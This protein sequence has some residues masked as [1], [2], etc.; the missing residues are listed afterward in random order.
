[1]VYK[2][3][4]FKNEI[5]AGEWKTFFDLLLTAD[6]KLGVKIITQGNHIDFFVVSDKKVDTL[7]SR[8][9]PFYLS[10]EISVKERE[11]SGVAVNGALLA[12]ATNKS[13]FELIE[14]SSLDN[15]S[16]VE[17]EFSINR[18]NPFKTAPWLG[19]IYVKDRGYV[20]YKKLCL[21]HIYG[22][23]AFD[24]SRSIMFEVAKVR[25]VLARGGLSFNYDDSGMMEIRGEAGKFG[26]KSYDFWR[27]S[28]ILGQSGSGKSY[29][30]KLLID[31]LAKKMAGDYAVV[32][33]DPHASLDGIIAGV[34][35]REAIDFRN[36]RTDLF[37]NIGQ[38]TLS[39]ELTM[40]LFS[41][42]INI[43]ENQNLARVLK[44]SLNFLFSIDKMSLDNL[45]KLLTDSM[46]R[47]QILKETDDKNMLQFFETEYQQ[48]QSGQYTTAV[49]PVINLISELDFVTNVKEE[50]GLAEAINSH[51]LTTIPIKQ[52]ELGQN[53]TR[54]IGGAIIQQ[55]F[56]IMQA[57]L[58]KKKVLLIVDEVSVVQTPS[59][60]HILSEARKFGL[61]VVLTQQYLLQVSGEVL[62]SIFANTVNYF[63]FKLARED[64]D[65]VAKNL[66]FEIDEYF[67]K[68][69]NDPR[70]TQELGVKLLT[71]LNPQEVIARVMSDNRYSPPFKSKTVNVL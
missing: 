31:D 39:T 11:L 6:W 25:P 61:T 12:G 41:T 38:P 17:I 21:K 57:G 46:F 18:F 68:N 47:K 32:L 64:A 36:K 59:L 33:V 45:K 15:E 26:V 42:V 66:N 8:L 37:I 22:F 23:L 34:E 2:I 53:V 35:S 27:H 24:L 71:D 52:T 14:K 13:L 4:F 49:L 5:N 20:K 7:N 70:E 19:L 58:V 65:I 29:L 44:Y 51:F 30:I 16:L 55:V 69:K 9:F 63:C 10:D 67:L 3:T 54:L 43:K 50:V 56:T 60:V 1:M 62:S 48:L 40:D 28:L